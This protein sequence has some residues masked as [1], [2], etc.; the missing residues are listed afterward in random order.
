MTIRSMCF[1]CV[2]IAISY[3]PTLGFF[4]ISSSL[5]IM[6]MIDWIKV[7][8]QSFWMWYCFC[9]SLSDALS[10]PRSFFH[11]DVYLKRFCI[12]WKH[13]MTLGIDRTSLRYAQKQYN[14]QNGWIFPLYDDDEWT[15]LFKHFS[16]RC[17]TGL[18]LRLH[19]STWDDPLVR[20]PTAAHQ[21]H[22]EKKTQ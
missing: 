15:H 4:S 9:A 11:F 22:L 1:L 21:Q 3:T 13:E 14:I 19:P 18:L 8:I 2:H 20:V 16:D 12:I 17:A 5:M 10:T 7:K 6:V